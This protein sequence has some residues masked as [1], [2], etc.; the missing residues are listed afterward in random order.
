MSLG[1]DCMGEESFDYPDYEVAFVL[2]SK[3]QELLAKNMFAEMAKPEW[4]GA[5]DRAFQYAPARHF[6]IVHWALV[7]FVGFTLVLGLAKVGFN[8]VHEASASYVECVG[9]KIMPSF[10]NVRFL[11]IYVCLFTGH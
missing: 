5:F 7:Q 4:V 2:P 3:V 9:I 8:F 6:Y 10:A 1:H 11:W